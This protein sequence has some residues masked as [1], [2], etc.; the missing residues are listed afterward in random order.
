MTLSFPLKTLSDNTV[1]GSI[2]C[3]ISL[4][5]IDEVSKWQGCLSICILWLYEYLYPAIKTG[6]DAI[7]FA[8]APVFST[9]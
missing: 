3:Q 4:A 5:V 8:P 9:V 2:T 1:N 7:E 6:A